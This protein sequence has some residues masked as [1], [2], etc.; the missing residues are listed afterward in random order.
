MTLFCGLL[1]FR[2]IIFYRDGL[3]EA[4]SATA[5]LY[6]P[7]NHLY[8]SVGFGTITICTLRGGPYLVAHMLDYLLLEL[9]I[10]EALQFQD[11]AVLLCVPQF[12]RHVL[13]ILKYT[14]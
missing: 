13:L 8:C 7:A 11:L 9:A 14:S 2:H 4:L 3:G 5:L 12:H 1:W 10:F 6:Y